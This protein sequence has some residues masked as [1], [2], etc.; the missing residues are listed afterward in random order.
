MALT[1]NGKVVFV[2]P[3]KS[4]NGKHYKRLQV[5][6]EGNGHPA[7]LE[8]VTDMS[9][10]DWQFGKEVSLEVSLQVYQGKK[11]LGYSFTY[12]GNQGAQS[13]GPPPTVAP[14]GDPTPSGA[15]KSGAKFS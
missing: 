2:K 11:G 15:A 3:E 5:F 1:I 10:S 9:N 13:G 12:W 14:P 8:N 6:S 4:E 7:S